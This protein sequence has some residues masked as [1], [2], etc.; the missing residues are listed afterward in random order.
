MA[1][2]VETTVQVNVRSDISEL[3]KLETEM[4]RLQNIIKHYETKGI[5]LIHGKD[6]Q[7]AQIALD[8]ITTKWLELD[9]AIKNTSKNNVGKELNK[10][11][12]S[13]EP[14]DEM[15]HNLEILKS[16]RNE[17]EQL[18]QE[19]SKLNNNNFNTDDLAGSLANI[20]AN[21]NLSANSIG[22]LAKSLGVTGGQA[23]IAAASFALYIKTIES[24][25]N[26]CK[27]CYDEVTTMLGAFGTGAIEGIKWTIDAVEELNDVLKEAIQA[28]NEFADVGIESQQGYFT[29]YNYL[30]DAGEEVVN[31]TNNLQEAFGLDSSKLV[32]S[33]RGVL[34]MVSNMNLA[35]E[36]ATDT[37]KAFTM[38]G[39]ELSAF[40]GYNFEEIVGQL[41]SAVNLGTIRANSPI[42]RA[43]DLTKEDVEAFRELNSVEERAQFLLS[44]GEKLRGTYEKWLQTSAGKVQTLKDSFDILNS[45]LGRLVTGLLGKLAPALTA[46]VNTINKAVDGL[47]KLFHVDLTSL[48]ENSGNAEDA[49]KGIADSIEAVGEAADNAS[50]KTAPFDDLIQIS[51]SG[52][53]KTNTAFSGE[54]DLGDWVQDINTEKSDL[55]KALDEIYK[56]LVDK[57]YL[58]AGRKLA[59]SLT[60]WISNINWGE[61]QT[62]FTK[63]GIAIATFLDGLFEKTDLAKT[64]GKTFAQL[65]N[66][67]IAGLH[68]FLIGD[69][70]NPEGFDFGKLGEWLGA[71]WTAYWTSFDSTKLGQVLYGVF[72]G[73]VDLVNG[74]LKEGGLGQLTGAIGDT[75]VSFFNNFTEEDITDTANALIGLID[76]VFNSVDTLIDKFKDNP[77]I[78]ESLK[79]VIKAAIENVKNNSGDWGTTLNELI[80]SI[81][82]FA[83]ET[84]IENESNLSTA[85]SNFLEALKLD[86]ILGSWFR[87]KIALWM[88]VID[89]TLVT[90]GDDIINLLFNPLGTIGDFLSEQFGKLADIAGDSFLGKLSEW[91]SNALSLIEQVFYVANPAS[92]GFKLGSTVGNKIN[93]WISGW[94]IPFA[95]GGIVNGATHALIGEAGKEVVLPLE[96]NTGWMADLASELVSKMNISNNTRSNNITIDMSGY[97][98]NF[99]TR[100]EMLEFGKQVVEALKLYGVNVAAVY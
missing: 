46:I 48:Q 99:Y 92:A 61:I 19:Q 43:L 36:Q 94:E 12:N 91:I 77:K 96:N 23:A 47:A 14:S 72:M 20:A 6:L 79:G 45:S 11:V 70:D 100:S 1:G 93:D 58:D 59:D 22:Q 25:I 83:S 62:K 24:V 28:M 13:T 9:A 44:R 75:I 68:G 16:V 81:L 8:K 63:G 85:I 2:K 10:T 49:Y 31:F 42:V 89:S 56:L 3:K 17:Q 38:F 15:L 18:N 29:L 7:D 90:L 35:A 39:Q 69:L 52:Q 98:K 60:G 30:G 33:L 53:A 76:D 74:W 37:V 50:R 4:T 64:V 32:G 86:E 71:S 21:G 73:A 41:E 66:T 40:S 67:L 65:P 87:D 97:T 80:T 54:L 55:Q 95:T 27:Q 51:D 5:T 82:D 84:L 26:V 57:K 78:A 34:G 88:P